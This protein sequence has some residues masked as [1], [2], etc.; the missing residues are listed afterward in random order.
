M[1]YKLDQICI[2]TK[3]LID[4]FHAFFRY[5]NNLKSSFP[6]DKVVS[7]KLLRGNSSA[8]RAADS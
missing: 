6:Q 2:I 4:E 7:S 5:P 1:T 8:V 3:Y